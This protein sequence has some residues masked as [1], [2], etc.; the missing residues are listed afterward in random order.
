MSRTAA[1]AIFFGEYRCSVDDKGR[2]KMP[3]DLKKQFP[4]EDTGAFVMAKGLDDCLMIYPL[5]T[6]KKHEEMLAKLDRLKADH[7]AFIANFMTGLTRVELDQNDRFLL[8]K[9]LL[10]Y[11]SFP[12][13]VIVRSDLDQLQVWEAS[14]YDQYVNDSVK[15]MDQ[16]S[17][18]VSDY[19]ES[20][21]QK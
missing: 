4:A 9:Q 20:K 6:W 15:K 12:K 13:E 19:L 5:A 14:R 18:S 17:E 7:R 3:V 16:L 1:M 21:Q 8:P 11:I 10:K 2:I